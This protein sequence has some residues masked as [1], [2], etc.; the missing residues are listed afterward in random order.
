MYEI[1]VQYGQGFEKNKNWLVPVEEL[2]NVKLEKF[3][4]QVVS[5]I[6][7]VF[8]KEEARMMY[9]DNENDFVILSTNTDFK[10]ALRCADKQQM[11]RNF[12]DFVLE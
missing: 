4:D 2:T 5:V 12:I 10:Y 1:K 9:R 11:I 8:P 6:G 3:K 7:A